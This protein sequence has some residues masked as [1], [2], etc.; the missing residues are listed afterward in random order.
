MHGIISGTFIISFSWILIKLLP[1]FFDRGIFV[2]KLY[3]HCL[4]C[5][6]IIFHLWVISKQIILN[7]NNLFIRNFKCMALFQVCLLHHFFG[8]SGANY[9]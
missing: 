9:C 8:Y 6:I 4:T 7:L 5:L 1:Y 3:Q 2:N